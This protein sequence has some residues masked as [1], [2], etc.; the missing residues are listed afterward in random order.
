M[1]TSMKDMRGFSI[2]AKDGDLGKIDDAYFDDERW[3]VRYLVVDVGGWLS[4]RKVLISPHAI[5]H[6]DATNDTV[7]TLLTRSQVEN[8][9]PIETTRP[10]SR[11]M[12]A[13]YNQ[14]YGYPPYWAGGYATGLW[15]FGAMPL[16][17]TE[18]AMRSA[19]LSPEA[20]RETPS[21]DPSE[22]HLRSGREVIGYHVV[23]TDRGIG[24][25]DDFLLEEG[26]WAIRYVVVDTRDW[27][28][29]KH[30]LVSPEHVE[31]VSWP[32]RSVLVDIT[33]SEVERSPEYD[34]RHLPDS[35]VAYR[36]PT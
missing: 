11:R 10:I 14:Y 13:E 2:G 34:G 27:W 29:G 23:A 3:T 28:P 19:R 31:R 30:V 6:V 24:H 18:P 26:T 17:A 15:G 21:V 5:A 8:S 1:L 9:P 33:R 16:A 32:E 36:A 35:T 22:V 7:A 25:I 20:A 4:G 12:E